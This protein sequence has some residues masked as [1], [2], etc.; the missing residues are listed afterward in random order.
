MMAAKKTID[1]VGYMELGNITTEF[2]LEMI[3][4][5]NVEVI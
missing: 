2:W 1:G 5:I 4:I 3:I